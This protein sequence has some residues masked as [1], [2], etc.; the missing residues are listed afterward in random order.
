MAFSVKFR[1]ME[2]VHVNNRG[3]SGSRYDSEHAKVC[4]AGY[5]SSVV[6]LDTTNKKLKK[7]AYSC[8]V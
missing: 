6:N 2:I 5:R 4:R 3:V 8:F 7:L 1:G